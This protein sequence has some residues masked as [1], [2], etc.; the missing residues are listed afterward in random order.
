MGH[1]LSSTPSPVDPA[2][3]ES[4]PPVATAATQ[5]ASASEMRLRNRL[6]D[7][8][9]TIGRGIDVADIHPVEPARAAAR[10]LGLFATAVRGESVASERPITLAS[11]AARM[12]AAVDAMT[13]RERKIYG[14]VHLSVDAMDA[15]VWRYEAAFAL[16]WGLGMHADLGE[17]GQLPWPDQRCDLHAVSRLVLDLSHVDFLATAQW[18]PLDELLDAADLHFRAWWSIALAQSDGG[19]GFAALDPG[20]VA[21]R[22]TALAWALGLAPEPM[23][24]WDATCDWIESGMGD[25]SAA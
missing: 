21:E 25:H 6:I 24:T 22:W 8:P 14:G 3:T 2:A 23:R 19:D 18:R 13:D 11:I 7:V 1:R 5:R 9:D 15:A 4:F 10:V 20:V 12:P 17:D 16:Q